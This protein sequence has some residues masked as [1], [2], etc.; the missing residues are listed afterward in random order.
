MSARIALVS[1]TQPS[2]NPRARKA[3][4]ALVAAGYRVDILHPILLPQH[5]DEDQALAQTGGWRSVIYADLRA[6]WSG[7]WLRA[8]RRLAMEQLKMKL[9]AGAHALGYGVGRACA[10]AMAQPYALVI[11]HQELGLYVAWRCA[12]RGRRAAVDLEDWYS[13][14]LP[15]AARRTRPIALLQRLEKWAG[16]HAAFVTTTTRV[17]ANAFAIANHCAP[18]EVVYN[19]FDPASTPRVPSA[20]E[21]HAERLPSLHWFSQTIGP[22]RG[23]ELLWRALARLNQPV[24]LVLRGKLASGYGEVLKELAAAAPTVRWS[25]EPTVPNDALLDAV[26]VHDLALALEIPYCDNKRYT[27]SNKIL[28]SL[29]AGL[30]VLATDTPGQREIMEQ[31]P[32][33]GW[34]VSSGSSES[35]TRALEQWLA[36]RAHWP[37]M[38]TA[39]QAAVA[40]RLSWAHQ[41]PTLLDCVAKALQPSR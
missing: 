22:Q 36:Q 1:G 13:R 9:G 38:R 7:R 39:A 4:A 15:G 14:D 29:A 23:L 30:P 31:A 41:V 6:P 34:V 33:A 20:H 16:H 8:R 10:A 3:A 35:M 21:T 12:R 18:P 28:Q 27:A 5:I 25:V 37:H 17:M 24:A 40:S 19:A 32:G 2:Q 11:G 26:A